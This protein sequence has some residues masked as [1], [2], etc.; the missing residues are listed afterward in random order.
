MLAHYLQQVFSGR[1]AEVLKY[2][3]GAF[4]AAI[5]GSNWFDISHC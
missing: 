4:F 2:A 3:T 1:A 5:L